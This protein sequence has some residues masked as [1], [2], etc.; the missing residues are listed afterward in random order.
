VDGLGKLIIIQLERPDLILCFGYKRN[1]SKRKKTLNKNSN[2]KKKGDRLGWIGSVG[3][4]KGS[5]HQSPKRTTEIH[6]VFES[7]AGKNSISFSV[8]S[9]AHKM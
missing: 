3:G 6:R 7:S 5:Q 2:A 8:G 4:G 1:K 9:T